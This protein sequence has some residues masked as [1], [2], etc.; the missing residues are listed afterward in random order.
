MILRKMV[1]RGEVRIFKHRVYISALEQA[2]VLILGKYVLLTV[3]NTIYKHAGEEYRRGINFHELY[4]SA[5]EQCFQVN[6]MQLCSF[7]IHK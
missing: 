1:R 6:I 5:L 7:S 4:I 3:I 2:R